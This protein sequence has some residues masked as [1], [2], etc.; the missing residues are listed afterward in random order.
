VEYYVAARGRPSTRRRRTAH[1]FSANYTVRGP[2]AGS[3]RF[4]VFVHAEVLNLFNQFQ[5][6]G[7][8][9]SV[10][11]NGGADGHLE[12][13]QGVTVA[14][15]PAFDPFTTVPVK[16]TQ[17]QTGPGV[18]QGHRQVLLHVTPAPSGSRSA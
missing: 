11:N 12:I 6:C 5:L 2:R 7:C 18:R 10:F 9:G 14:G 3:T 13:N 4:D 16:D 1:D 17:L 8:G 15:L